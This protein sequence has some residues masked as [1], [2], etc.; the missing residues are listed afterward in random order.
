[1]EVVMSDRAP[2]R[3]KSRAER[4]VELDAAPLPKIVDVDAKA[5]R[6]A[7]ELE[8]HINR[9]RGFI[10]LPADDGMIR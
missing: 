1:M 10:D 2:G 8:R 3:G 4:R 7:G 9:A 6:M 5:D